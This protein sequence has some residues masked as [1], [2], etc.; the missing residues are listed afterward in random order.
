MLFIVK[1]SKLSIVTSALS[2][3][4][5]MENLDD[6]NNAVQ[7]AMRHPKLVHTLPALLHLNRIK[8]AI[9][10]RVEVLT[11][12]NRLCAELTEWLG[13]TSLVIQSRN[14]L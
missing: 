6:K 1:D 12:R 2:S 10:K 7:D 9:G 13:I 8:F 5:I 11:D 14:Y 4:S 3:R